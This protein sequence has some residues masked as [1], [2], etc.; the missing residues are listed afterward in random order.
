MNLK[1]YILSFLS[2][3]VFTSVNNQT[4]KNDFRDTQSTLKALY[5]YNFATLTD[6]PTNYKKADFEIAIISTNS[7]VYNELY[8]KYNGKSIGSQKVKTVRYKSPSEIGKPNIL[9]L[10][11]SS[12]S[13][14][15]K[16]NEKL[17]S[18]STMFVTNKPGALKSG[19]II[20]FVEVNNKQSYEI[21]VKT[22]KKKKLVIASKLIDL[23]IK[24]IE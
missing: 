23:A 1:F 19:S 11:K 6:W 9:F 24:K 10:D 13:L 8:K 20:N 2:L 22:A 3:F 12:N 18:S 7:N 15:T 5:I 21:N 4:G 17:K 16:V 14:M